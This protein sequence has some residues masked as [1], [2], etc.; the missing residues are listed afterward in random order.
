MENLLNDSKLEENEKKFKKFEIDENLKTKHAPTHKSADGKYKYKGNY[1]SIKR[2][3]GGNQTSDISTIHNSS[4][5]VLGK[6]ENSGSQRLIKNKFTNQQKSNKVILEHIDTD[7]NEDQET[8]TNGSLQTAVKTSNISNFFLNNKE[9]K[10]KSNNI[11]LNRITNPKISPSGTGFAIK[12]LILN[13]PQKPPFSANLANFGKSFEET[14][15]SRSLNQAIIGETKKPVG[16]FQLQN[17]FKKPAKELL[18][19]KLNKNFVSGNNYQ[20]SGGEEKITYRL[21][22]YD[23]NT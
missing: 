7:P 17:S 23:S 20:F 10:S 15:T 6:T 4:D 8:R 13:Q 1:E 2:S 12:K 18:F 11:K 22:N 5:R 16:E 19:S 21:Q 9:Y 3:N 14:T